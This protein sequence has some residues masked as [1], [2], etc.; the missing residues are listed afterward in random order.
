MGE[1]NVFTAPLVV[2]L[3]ERRGD[4]LIRQQL[5]HLLK[6]PEMDVGSPQLLGRLFF[7]HKISD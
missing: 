7:Y 3:H 6:Q 5:F 4:I 2:V 1:D